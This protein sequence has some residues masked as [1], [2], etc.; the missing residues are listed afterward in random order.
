MTETEKYEIRMQYN[1]LS[2]LE[3]K[4]KNSNFEYDI[5]NLESY[6]K[7]QNEFLGIN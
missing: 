2:K 4:F 7:V 6:K 1:L 3:I 5:G